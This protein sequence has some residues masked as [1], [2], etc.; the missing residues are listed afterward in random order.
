MEPLTVII[1]VFSLL[2]CAYMAWNI[3]ANDVANAMGT[4]VGSRALTLKQAVVLAAVFE[5]CGAFF[6]G[7]AVTDTVRKGILVVDFDTVTLDF[8]NDLMFGFIAAMMAAAVWLTVATRFGLPVSTTHSI[9]GG[10]IGVGLIL[11]VQHNTSLIDWFVVQKVVLSWIASP[12]IGAI[13]AFISFYVVRVTILDAPDPIARA[14]W[15]APLLALP[16]FFVLGLALQFKALKGFI[17][18]LA[19]DG[20]IADKYD[21]LPVK[22][23]GS[24][25]PFAENAWFPINSLLA[26]LVIGIIAS[27]ILAYVLRNFESKREGFQ[28][29]ERIFVWLQIITAAYVAF[30]HGANDR[31]NAIGPMA[32]VYQ[33]I[34]SGGELSA[35]ADIPLWLILLGSAGIAIGVMTWG[36]RVMDTI[37]KKITE[38]TPT[39]GFAAEFG[40]AT[41]ILFFS[42]PFLAVPVSTTHTLVGAVVG[43]GLAGGA[44]AVDFRVFGKIAASWVASV[45][46]AAFG[47]IIL[48]IATGSN[49]L[50]ML[51]VFP[52][53]F[54]AVG[55]AIW[56]TRG[57]EIHVDE[58]LAGAVDS[59]MDP[60]VF[61]LFHAHAV[62][63]EQT[64][65]KMLTAVNLVADGK[66]ASEAIQATSAS[67]LEADIL[68]A[69][70]RE[71][72]ANR[73][74]KMLVATDVFLHMLTRQDRIADYAENVAEQLSFREIYQDKQALV[75]LKEMAEA[76]N[77]TAAKY[78]DT[79]ECL[80]DFTLS[81]YTKSS[82]EE[83]LLLIKDVNELE[84]KAD[85][86][87]HKA[88]GYV[89]SHGDE[90]AL[91]AI[92]MYRVLQR[93]DDV[94]NSCEKSANAF[95]PMLYD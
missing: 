60:T 86:A 49:A 41:T 42:M 72:I 17:S 87:E 81:G 88:A 48:Y 66:D 83:L 34:S 21:W 36:Y 26:A 53:A 18:K 80:R 10:I 11:E 46:V 24:F 59:Q 57:G 47:A 39:R 56:K 79:V 45:P 33:I 44:K 58:A 3:G 27:T 7:D 40:A 9:I 37:G 25:N 74:I 19:A 22:E 28:G 38:I 4:S 12:L 5:F 78:E 52:L 13:L 14:K 2:V 23:N 61:E 94:A 20:V 73:E 8:A 93:L 65:E 90:D 55:F 6:A 70:I 67:E 85:K 82:R 68:K 84:H 32:A 91:A 1:L 92:H 15:I 43:V 50:N 62:V 54:M 30:A 76:V 77:K 29:V 31:S 63:V 16:T 69:A 75:L 89:F 35:Q 51:V 64:V 71:M 95:L